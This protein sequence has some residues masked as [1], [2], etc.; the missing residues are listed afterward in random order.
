MNAFDSALVQLNTAAKLLKLDKNTIELLSKPQR[1]VEVNIPLKMDKGD[2]KFFKGFRVQ[3]NNWLGPYKGGLRYHPKVDLDEVQ[4]LSFWMMIKN[5]LVGVPFGGGK[6]GIEVDPKSL[7]KKE[8]EKLTKGFAKLLAW[9]VGPILDVPAPDVNTNAETMD[10]FASEY[11]K[12]V[13]RKTK[14]VVTGKSIKNGG[15]EGREEATGLGGFFVL[16]EFVK[17]VGWKKPALQASRPLTVAIQGFGNVGSHMAR[18]LFDK[19]YKVVVISD[20]KGGV[21]DD[22]GLDVRAV[23]KI[24]ESGGKVADFKGKRITNEDLLELK[25]DILI[26]AA[27]EGVINKENAARVQAKVVFEM[28]NGPTTFEADEILNKRR[29]LVVP[30]VL[31][32][33]GGV[34][35]SYFE[36]YQ[37]MKGE[38]WNLKQV[39]DRLKKKMVRAFNDVWNVHKEK[40]VNLR[41]AAYMVALKRLVIT[42]FP[43]HSF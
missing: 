38:R 16:E 27:L 15:S 32:N 33:S 11:S 42:P 18:L 37:N 14:A 7:S 17:E 25:V 19:G 23:E 31:C 1:Q 39:E 13:G 28:A 26:P 3:Y 6:G 34:T 2:L 21:F 5:A 36:W 35:V 9:D 29:V 20:S 40:K 24:K 43:R 4:A 12:A 8:L 10:W 22:N 41:T 30:D